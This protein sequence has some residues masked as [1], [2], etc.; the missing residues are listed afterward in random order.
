VTWLARKK[1]LE[2]AITVLAKA[3]PEGGPPQADRSIVGSTRPPPHPSANSA[4]LLEC[5]STAYEK[6]SKPYIRSV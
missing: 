2:G 1:H 6:H 5:S 4:L 3:D